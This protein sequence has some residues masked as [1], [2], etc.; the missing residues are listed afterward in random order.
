MSSFDD[1]VL[2][3]AGLDYTVPAKKMMGAIARIEDHVTL[4]ELQ[5]YGERGAVPLSRLAAAFASVLRYAGAKVADEDVYAAMFEGEEQQEAMAVS[6]NVLLAMMVP[7][8]ARGKLPA[9]NGV[10]GETPGGNSVT[11]A[12]NLSGKRSNSRAAGAK[13]KGGAPRRSS[14]ISRSKNSTG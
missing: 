6:V 5:A 2:H 8:S 11:A 1:V 12:T 3:W 7:K 14:G 13:V 10:G 4:P 9:V